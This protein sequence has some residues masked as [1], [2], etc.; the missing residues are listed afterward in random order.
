LFFGKEGR[1]MKTRLTYNI[2]LKILAV[3]AASI[4]WLVVVNLDDPVISRTFS[5]I[6]VEVKNSDA[7]TSEGKIY[8]VLDGSDS[9]SVV[10]TGKRSVIDN[11]S[12]DNIKATA[13]MMDMTFM[14]T[15]AIDVKT[16]L[17]SDKIESIVPKTKN[18]K[19][20][21]EDL[22]KKQFSIEVEA[23]GVP[24]QGYSLGD[25]SSNVNIASISG[26]ISIVSKIVRA[27]VTVDASGLSKDI[28]TSSKV[29]LYDSNDEI[30][31]SDMITCNVET[32][33]VTVEMLQTKD[34]PVYFSISGNAADGYGATGLIEST[35]STVTIAGKSNIL[36]GINALSIPQEV[37]S[38][39]GANATFETA[40]D[41]SDFLPEGIRFA[42]SS[43][44]GEVVATVYIDALQVKEV[45]IPTQ[46]ITFTNIP[47]GYEAILTDIGGSLPVKVSGLG[48]A[49]DA[50]DGS[51]VTGVIDV[52]EVI[53]QTESD[54]REEDSLTDLYT[55]N[56]V[57]T[58]P[59]GISDTEQKMMSFVLRKT[60]E[61][62]TEEDFPLNK[63]TSGDKKSE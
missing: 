57:F 38:I 63:E 44:T 16:T 42:D 59:D 29:E 36:N 48:E 43:F 13:D 18:L 35:P 14:D 7:I 53:P 41:I 4:L 21:I 9:I 32:V 39:N 49:F 47:E 22:A 51:A 27:V 20:L 26:P 58:Y 46:G 33:H 6:S 31:E 3:L 50:F 25:V 34:I 45:S 8:E 40:V 23:T 52:A 61:E 19:V 54:I 5:P 17:Y 2:G 24:E 15:V 11:L 1:R 56:V 55:G 28:S 62:V 30:V 37:L 10:V 12:K 60:G